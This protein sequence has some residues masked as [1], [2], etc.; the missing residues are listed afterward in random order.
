MVSC[1]SL[2]CN[3]SPLCSQP[4][5]HLNSPAAAG[6]RTRSMWGRRKL[7]WSLIP[8]STGL[9]KMQRLPLPSQCPSSPAS[10]LHSSFHSI[11]TMPQSKPMCRSQQC[12]FNSHFVQICPWHGLPSL[13]PSFLNFS[14]VT[15]SPLSLIRD[16]EGPR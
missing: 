5:H 8:F 7:R 10:P 2:R 12:S 9:R 15:N 16:L 3:V 11:K 14:S 1:Q 4:L 6:A 13:Y